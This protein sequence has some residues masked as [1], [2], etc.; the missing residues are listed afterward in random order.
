LYINVNQIFSLNK[1]LPRINNIVLSF[2]EADMT[3]IVSGKRTLTIGGFQKLLFFGNK[4]TTVSH[5][6]TIISCHDGK[7][8]YKVDTS[9][10]EALHT[11]LKLRVKEI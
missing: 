10:K 3:S 6:I 2:F 1:K 9:V 7:H 8:K 11:W 4:L 5:S